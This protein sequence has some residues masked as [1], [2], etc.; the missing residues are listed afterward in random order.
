[1]FADGDVELI[2]IQMPQ[3]VEGS[4]D[5]SIREETKDTS[6]KEDDIGK[7]K[8]GIIHFA[9]N[10]IYVLLFTGVLVSYA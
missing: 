5:V 10:I 8:R 7:K 2:G 9:P 3:N 6:R 4:R 1:M